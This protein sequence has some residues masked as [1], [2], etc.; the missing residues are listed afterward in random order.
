[1]TKF[2][3]RLTRIGLAVV[4]AWCLY[5]AS[6]I[7]SFAQQDETRPA[8]VA[9]VLGAAAWRDRPSP[10]LRERINHA[11]ALFQ[12]GVVDAIIFTGGYGRNDLLSESETAREYALQAGLPLEALY[13]EANSTNTQQNLSEAQRLMQALGLQ[14]ALI[15]SD[16][17]HMMRAMALADDLGIEAYSSPTT[18][19]RYASIPTQLWF[20]LRET[21]YYSGYLLGY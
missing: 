13:I 12:D 14:S 7:Y 9:I 4:L 3:I 6:S 20:L 17:M 10:V 2:L 1:M 11:I 15:V 8:D 16:P 19:S 18:T 5:A 21:A